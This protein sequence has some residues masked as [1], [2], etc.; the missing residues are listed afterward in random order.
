MYV[1]VTVL[2]LFILTVLILWEIVD[3]LQV[4][5]TKGIKQV[6]PTGTLVT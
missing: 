1:M 3:P 5:I 6:R 4:V 2:V